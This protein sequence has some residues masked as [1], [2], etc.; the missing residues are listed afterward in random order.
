MVGWA[1]VIGEAPTMFANYEYLASITGFEGMTNAVRVVSESFDLESAKSISSALEQE[2]E[3]GGF[4][5]LSVTTLAIKKKVLEDHILITL[6]LLMLLAGL[7]AIVGG[8]GLLSS[9]SMNVIERTR[10]IGIMQAI[11]ASPG[12]VQKIVIVEGVLIGVV[13]WLGAIFLSIPMGLVIGNTAGEVIIK[14]PLD[15]AISPVG[16]TAW[17]LIVIVFSAVASYYP[18]QRATSLSVNDILAYE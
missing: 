15:F 1:R 11:G 5:T 13:S 16:M 7:A 18:A 4:A 9:M 6:V 2:L 14:V 8:L 10:E 17:L 3:A 12:I